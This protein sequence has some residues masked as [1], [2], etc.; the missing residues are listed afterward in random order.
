MK[1][2]QTPWPTCASSWLPFKSRSVPDDGMELPVF[3]FVPIDS[4]IITK[5]HWKEPVSATFIPSLQ[6]FIHI[7]EFSLRLLLSR[8]NQAL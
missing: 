1:T 7:D 6:V 3:M 5:H 4:C 2:T 8:L